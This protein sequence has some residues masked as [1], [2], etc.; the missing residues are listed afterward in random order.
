MVCEDV[1][2]ASVA[3]LARL[4][5]TNQPTRQHCLQTEINHLVGRI[6]EHYQR[7]TLPYVTLP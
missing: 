1:I 6:V 3:T 4:K 2:L 5:N 7:E